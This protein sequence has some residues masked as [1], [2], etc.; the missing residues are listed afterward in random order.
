MPTRL[1]TNTAKTN[2]QRERIALELKGYLE[3][4]R[5]DSVKRDA[6]NAA[7]MANVTLTG[8]TSYTFQTDTNQNRTLEASEVSSVSFAGYN[9]GAF[10]GSLVY[11]LKISFDQQG[12]VLINNSQINTTQTFKICTSDCV[13]ESSANTIIVT[14]SP[15]GTAAIKAGGTVITEPT[16]PTVTNVD[17]N[18]GLRSMTL[19]NSNL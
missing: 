1:Q 11:P 17:P 10:V 18:T 13:N 12:H 5:F 8:S 2:L 19:V 7:E 9:S 15:A 4:A 3:R 16:A 6:L 14:L